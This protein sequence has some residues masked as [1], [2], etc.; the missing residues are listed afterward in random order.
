MGVKMN[1]NECKIEAPRFISMALKFLGE[2]KKKK[3]LLRVTMRRCRMLPKENILF[4]I[5][6]VGC[7]IMVDSMQ[8]MVF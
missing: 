1:M 5:L 3:L 4:A 2:R 6:L 8:R 7:F